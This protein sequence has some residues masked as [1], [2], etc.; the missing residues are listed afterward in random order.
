MAVKYA[1]VLSADEVLTHIK[2]LP[3]TKGKA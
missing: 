3:D 1:D 2:A